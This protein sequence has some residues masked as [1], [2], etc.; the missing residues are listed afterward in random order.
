MKFKQFKKYSQKNLTSL[1]VF[2]SS[3]KC[4]YLK[5]EAASINRKY[6]KCAHALI[7]KFRSRSFILLM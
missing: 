1:F 4:E 5:K 3:E 6:I 7:I 2:V